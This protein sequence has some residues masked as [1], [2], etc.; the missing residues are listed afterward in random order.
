MWC[1][2]TSST[3]KAVVAG[4]GSYSAGRALCLS[5]GEP[6]TV[7]DGYARAPSTL[8]W[9][10]VTNATKLPG[11]RGWRRPQG[12]L[13]ESCVAPVVLEALVDLY[14]FTPLCRSG[15]HN[16][17]AEV[18]TATEEFTAARWVTKLRNA[19][20]QWRRQAAGLG[21]ARFASPAGRLWAGW[22]PTS[23]GMWCRRAGSTT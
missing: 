22:T 11:L 19:S 7:G 14:T 21:W 6:T 16:A 12:E 1:R 20:V 2:T 15:S 10:V 17:V 9:R 23:G 4:G 8:T 18:Q 13:D 5:A 3:S